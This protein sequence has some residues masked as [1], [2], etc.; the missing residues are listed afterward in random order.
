MTL[1]RDLIL[2][3]DHY[4]KGLMRMPGGRN[5]LGPLWVDGSIALRVRDRKQR[6]WR[7]VKIRHPYAVVGRHPRSDLVID[8]PDVAEHHVFLFLDPRGLFGVDLRTD[9]GTRFAGTEAEAAWLGSG[10]LIEVGDQTIE[11]IQLR[12]NGAI[13]SGPL[14]ND[15]PLGLVEPTG[16]AFR[17]DL[18]LRLLDDPNAN[19]SIGSALVFLGRGPACAVQLADRDLG[20]T[21]SAILRDGPAVYLIPFPGEAARV[22]DQDAPAAVRLADADVVTI[23][24]DSLL[25]QTHEIVAPGPSAPFENLATR[26]EMAVGPDHF[27]DVGFAFDAHQANPSH[28]GGPIDYPALIGRLQAE[29]AALVAVLLRRIEALD[30][31]MAALRDRL[32]ADDQ[33]RTQDTRPPIE[34]LRWDLIPQAEIEAAPPGQAGVWLVER[35]RELETERRTTWSNVLN[36]ITSGRTID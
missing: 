15:D 30:E 29:T 2:D 5:N 9:A 21:H 20:P 3:S 33:A 11:V 10:D 23:G 32:D 17:H 8:R 27:T 34:K 18:T 19:W 28:H 26:L 14:S 7:M 22:N 31:E 35:L 4:S 16:A 1:H 25:I 6:S 13:L 36:R 12:V 24:R